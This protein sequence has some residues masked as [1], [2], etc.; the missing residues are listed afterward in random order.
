MAMADMAGD[1]GARG[2]AGS[3]EE[4]RGGRGWSER[5]RIWAE[6]GRRQGLGARRRAPRAMAM[7]AGDGRRRMAL[8]MAAMR[9]RT[10]A[11]R[12]AG[13]QRENPRRVGSSTSAA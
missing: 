3:T 7:A 6:G 10:D 1:M 9:R 2:G 13:K 4:D 5:R 12:T 11:A 8:N